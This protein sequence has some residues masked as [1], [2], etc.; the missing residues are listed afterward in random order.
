MEECFCKVESFSNDCPVNKA[1]DITDAK[2]CVNLGKTELSLPW[3][4]I[5]YGSGV[6]DTSKMFAQ[7][8]VDGDCEI[9]VKDVE[10]VETYSSSDIY[11]IYLLF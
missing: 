9:T 6:K 1:R 2:P 5:K 11:G 4:V 8:L 10:Q 7:L 3:D